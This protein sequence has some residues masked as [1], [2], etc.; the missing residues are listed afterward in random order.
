MNSQDQLK[1]SPAIVDRKVLPTFEPIHPADFCLY[2]VPILR[3][4]PR[5]VAQF[6][7]RAAR[8]GDE[9]REFHNLSIKLMQALFTDRGYSTIH[10]WFCY[11]SVPTSVKL[12]LG[13]INY[14][15]KVAI[16]TRQSPL[17]IQRAGGKK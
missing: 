8:D 17:R 3:K 5:A 2:W 14:S 10:K 1:A 6:K 4:D 12:A 16:A 9:N 7:L 13:A 15:W 11:Q